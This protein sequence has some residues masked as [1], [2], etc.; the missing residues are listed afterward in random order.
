MLKQGV[1]AEEV[2]LA[3]ALELLSFPR[4]LVSIVTCQSF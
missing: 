4:E 2:D 3:K 1:K